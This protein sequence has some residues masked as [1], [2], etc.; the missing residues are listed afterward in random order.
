MQTW[1]AVALAAPGISVSGS[2]LKVQ[3][4][5]SHEGAQDLS[6]A[7]DAPKLGVK[8]DPKTLFDIAGFSVKADVKDVLGEPDALLK[9][10]LGAFAGAGI[11]ALVFGTAGIPDA[12]GGFGSNGLAGVNGNFFAGLVVEIVLTFIFVIN[13]D[14]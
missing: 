4:G 6:L 5:L 12:T 10:G 14:V 1:D 9:L 7:V 13:N 8:P 11:L 2:P 3:L